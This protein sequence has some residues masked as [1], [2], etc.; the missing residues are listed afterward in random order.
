MVEGG[1][2]CIKYLMFFFN[3]IFFLCGLAIIIGGALVFTVYNEY[4]DFTGNSGNAV[5]IILIIVG[6]LIFVTG[7]I[8][9][10]GALKDN[11]CMMTTFATIMVILL[12]TEIG[13]GIAGYVLRDEISDTIE[14]NMETL[15]Y[16]DY[17]ESNA[18]RTLFDKMH[19]DLKCCGTNNY[20]DWFEAFYSD[21]E[22]I[23][24]QNCVP[25]SCCKVETAQCNY[26]DVSRNPE[27]AG[28]SLFT[29]G[30]ND[31]LSSLITDNIAI[32]A[33]VAIVV[34]VVEVFG[35][36]C[37]CCLVKAIKSDYEVV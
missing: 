36:I 16:N 22:C 17:L 29:Q 21:T 37:A 25:E 10:C 27:V 26:E 30:C 20:T 23:G 19:E 13:V 35:I 31:A 14:D 34:A 2:K 6:S 5:P 28:Q 12:I 32:I 18:T 8:G 7:F 3:F 33:A 11:H 4:V 1:A 24:N 9:C 15:M